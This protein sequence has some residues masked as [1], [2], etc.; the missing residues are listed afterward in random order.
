MGPHGRRTQVKA[1]NF[2]KSF[3]R[4]VFYAKPYYPLMIIALILS[5]GGAICTVFGPRILGNVTNEIQKGAI[6][7]SIDMNEVARLGIICAIIYLISGLCSYFASFVMSGA[8]QRLSKKLRSDISKKINRIPLKYFDQRTYGDVLSRVT[9]D[10]DNIS[11][12]LNQSLTQIMSS[13]TLFFGVLIMMF[14]ISASLTFISIG[15]LLV[16]F[17]IIPLIMK[18]AQ[19]QF[20]LQQKNL[21]DINGHIEETYS[22]H[23][24]IKAFNRE[25][26][27]LEKFVGINKR[28]YQSGWKSQFFS[29][30]MMPL[31]TFVGN[32]SYVAVCVFGGIKAANGLMGIGDIQSFYQYVRLFS[33]PLSQ[34][35]QITNVLQSAAAAAER[36]FEFLDEEEMS[37]DNPKNVIDRAKGNVVFDMVNFGY[38]NDKPIIKNFNC[39][40]QSGMKVAIVGPTGAGKT[41]LVNILMRF[42]EIQ[43]GGIY[44]DGINTLDI[45]RSN[46]RDQFAM[47]LQDTWLFDGTIKENLKYGNPNATDEQIINACKS[48]YI[49][50]FIMS[51]PNGYDSKIDEAINISQGQKQLLTIARA[52]IKNAPMLILDEATS[53]VDTRTEL[54]LQNAMN[55]LMI[56]RTS[57]VIAH[58]L[59]TIKDADMII[60]MKEGNVVE[61]GNHMN[62]LEKNGFYAEL[63]NSQFQE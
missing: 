52:M 23:L 63:Y 3:K 35:A 48:T 19:K 54:L 7:H 41:T 50:H 40:V 51:L 27:E 43:S 56:G 21:G 47:V 28:L 34:M 13:L 55:N 62:L 30:L 37:K 2:K 6:L 36:V 61:V 15:C 11:Q 46:L 58:R 4:I 14:T 49:H 10:V 20:R 57:F 32:L 9:N 59:S 5:I 22:G 39:F 26:E 53:S 31:M 42:Y 29:G 45:S 12:N 33:Q 60:V 44:I 25:D 24:V 1:K 18:I 17:L 8:V 38:Y 16:S